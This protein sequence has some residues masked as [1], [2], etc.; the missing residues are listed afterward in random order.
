M[1][2]HH[3]RYNRYLLRINVK[4]INKR[5]Y[6]KLVIKVWVA[7]NKTNVFG[8]EPSRLEWDFYFCLNG[9]NFHT[10]FLNSGSL[11]GPP[12]IYCIPQSHQLYT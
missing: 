7:K 12:H 3:V 10:T 5:G 9:F 4:D 2:P 11:N 1:N 6:S 8:N